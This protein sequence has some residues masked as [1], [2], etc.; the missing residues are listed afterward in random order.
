MQFFRYIPLIVLTAGGLALLAGAVR[1]NTVPNNLAAPYS[2]PPAAVADTAASQTLEAALTAL[3]RRGSWLEM[4]VRQRVRLP[5]LQY[6]AEGSY[7]AAPDHRFRLDL[8]TRVGKTTGT[9]LT[10]SDGATVW[11]A[12][13]SGDGAW[14]AV[15]R[16]AAPVR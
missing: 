13:R 5:E 8:Q 2:P 1:R 9:L 10:V 16:A 15:T 12:H 7:R 6:L 14:T 4:T 11:R 3:G